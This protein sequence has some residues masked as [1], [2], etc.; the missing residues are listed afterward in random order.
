MYVD[1]AGVLGLS[2]TAVRSALYEAQSDFDR[3]HLKFHEV[4][5]HVG[6][7]RTLGCHLDGARLCT[8]PTDE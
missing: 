1:N 4:D 7:G 8:R 5:L 2:D 3:D 6:G